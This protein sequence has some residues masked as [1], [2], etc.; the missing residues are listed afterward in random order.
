MLNGADELLDHAKTRLGCAV[1][2]TSADGLFTLEETEC[3]ADCDIAPCVQVNHRF[4]RATTNE[5]FDQL[6]DELASGQRADEVPSHGT[7]IRVERSVGLEANPAQ[8]QAER[9]AQ[10]EAQA[11]RA[12]AAK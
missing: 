8:I 10:A 12:E 7:L 1:G 6:I 9:K 4:V 5:A 2:A 3:L 11:A